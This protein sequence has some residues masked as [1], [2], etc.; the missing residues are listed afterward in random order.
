MTAVSVASGL[1]GAL[2][3][4]VSI[5]FWLGLFLRVA[6]EPN[7]VLR[8]LTDASYW[9]YLVHLPIVITFAGVLAPLHW[10]AVSKAACVFSATAGTCLLSYALLVRGS[11][12]SVLLNGRRYPRGFGMPT[13]TE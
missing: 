13:R 11:F 9:I 12:V 4:W 3:A 1:F 5:L 10:P 2:M 8:Y 6:H 7:R